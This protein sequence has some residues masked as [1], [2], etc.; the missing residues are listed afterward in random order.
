MFPTRLRMAFAVLL[1]VG[2]AMAAA[3]APPAD[4]P[5][6]GRTCGTAEPS[7]ALLDQ[8]RSA[9]ERFRAE[10]PARTSGGT[11]RVAFHIITANGKGQ[12]TD[13]QVAAQI[14]ELN[15]AYKGTGY[16]FEL[17][18][19]DRTENSNWYKMAPGSNAEA[20]AKQTLAVDPAHHLNLYTCAP[21]QKL[22]GWAYFPFS[23]PEDSFWHGV[24]VHFESLPGGAFTSYN[25]GRTA[26]H[27]VGH[28]LGLFHTFQGGCVE[29]GDE[30]D[31]TAFEAEPA[32]GCP[33]GRNT[34]PQPGFDPV[35]NYMD[36]SDDGC[37]TEFTAGQDVRMDDLVSVYRP[38]LFETALA[39]NVTR[40]EI[41]PAAIEPEESIRA[42]SFRGA[43]PNP[44]R[45][46][47]AIH[48]TLPV[49]GHVSLRVYD[50]AGKLVS[51]LVDASLPPGDHSAMFRSGTLPSGMYF[52]VLRVGGVQ[53][54]RS[55][56]LTR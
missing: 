38:S 33:I 22:L 27:E 40:N 37:L 55:V 19:V 39:A 2:F 26:V 18:S 8:S 1:M 12:V 47:T 24:V 56:V 36:Y 34:C 15:R 51:T 23:V 29:P 46:E 10:R 5:P 45:R 4:G 3:A 30:V 32:F 48:F 13:A 6:L 43:L 11:I 49:S 42:L 28:Y 25:L 21:G 53:V 16:K 44:F 31:D 17:A 35:Q 9:V 7:R 14:D 41:E 54:S 52:T 20:R 50:I